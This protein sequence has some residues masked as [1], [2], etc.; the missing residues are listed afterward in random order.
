[1]TTVAM[2][3]RAAFDAA[4]LE[5]MSQGDPMDPCGRCGCRRKGHRPGR[6]FSF[7][8][9][10]ASSGNSHEIPVRAPTSCDCPF[11][12]CSCVGFVEP[13]PGQKYLACTAEV[14]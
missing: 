8:K 6:S 14:A 1:M 12:I 5:L 2:I 11:C 7:A 4:Q 10:G 9:T 13:F 3:S